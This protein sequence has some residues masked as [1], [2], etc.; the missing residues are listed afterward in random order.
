[1][2]ALGVIGYHHTGKTTT[3]VALIKAL[4]ALGHSVSSIKDIHSEDY[5]AD[6]AGS[7]SDKHIK[8][9]S[10]AVYARGL[11]DSAL[12]FPNPLSL[13]EILPHFQSEFLIVEGMK[14][15]PLPKI[16]CAET[17]EQ[18]DEL[19]DDTTFA[20][21][22]MIASSITS[23][24]GLPVFCLETKLDALVQLVLQKSFAPL[25]DVDPECCAECG[26]SCYALAGQI[27]QGKLNRDACVLD[28]KPEL[29]L[30]VN[31]KAI[32]IVPFV[33]RLLR[34]TIRSF[35]NN[36]KDIDHDGEIEIRL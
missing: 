18:L 17:T 30:S 26:M 32:Q 14:S 27:V 16:V 33:Q 34:D 24:K 5:R 29:S 11:H 28:S 22:G 25:P 4:K 19:V 13:A 12:I 20:I 35:V 2:K 6:K 15:A 8:A 31:G 9:G 21:S 3:V 36:L 23:Y 10:D 1:M 7:N